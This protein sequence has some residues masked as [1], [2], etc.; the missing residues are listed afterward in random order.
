M[1]KTISLYDFRKGFEDMNRSN[2]FSYEGLTA[3]FEYFEQLEN[4]CSIEIELDV[5]AICCEY[6]E[7]E[8]IEEL[9]KNYS[10]IEDMEDLYN[11]TQVITFDGGFIIQDF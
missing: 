10:D 8:N 6:T 9:Q 11:H 3:L 1:K 7:Y 4:D 5:I 2:N